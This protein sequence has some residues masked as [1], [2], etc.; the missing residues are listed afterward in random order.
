MDGTAADLFSCSDSAACGRWQ[1]AEVPKPSPPTE[2]SSS[3]SAQHAASMPP[4]AP[5]RGGKAAKTGPSDEEQL[6]TRLVARLTRADLEGILAS[7]VLSGAVPRATVE[8]M[9]PA[10]ERTLERARKAV[11]VGGSR[12]GTGLGTG[13]VR[14]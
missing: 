3:A 12:E 13:L 1:G 10:H 9:L 4:K 6:V 5:R 14:V 2:G 7:T 11:A 8:A